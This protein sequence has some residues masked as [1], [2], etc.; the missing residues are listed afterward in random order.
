MG[1]EK[2]G[3][4][5]VGCGQVKESKQSA[6]GDCLYRTSADQSEE[7]REGAGMRAL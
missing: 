7:H 4:M 1:K 5:Q 3:K 6:G 2:K